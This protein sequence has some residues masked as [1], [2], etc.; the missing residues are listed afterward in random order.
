MGAAGLL[1]RLRRTP[2]RRGAAPTHAS[3]APYGPFAQPATAATIYLGIQ[4][5]R[6]WTRFCARRARPA[7]R[8][9]TTS[10]SPPTRCASRIA[11]A[12]HA[13]HRRRSSRTLHGR[14]RSSSASKRAGIA[15]ARH[16]LG[17]GVP[18]PSAARRA[19]LLARRSTRRPARCARCMPPVRMDGVEPVMGDVPSLGQHTDAILE[20][21][22]FDARHDR[23]LAAGGSDLMAIKPGWTG[24]VFEDF[25]GRRRLRAS[26]R[27]ARFSTPT[28]SGSPA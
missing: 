5:A 20:E 27:A 25:D 19:R 6:E 23:G 22:G 7:R 13:R 18:R 12:L 2:R 4:N 10:G 16:E 26:A 11:T 17:R 1:H 21:L 8:S 28:T 9:P 14:R 3:I 24:R 15:C